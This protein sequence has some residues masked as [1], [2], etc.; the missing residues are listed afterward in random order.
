[1]FRPSTNIQELVF[2]LYPDMFTTIDDFN[3]V[4]QHISWFLPRHYFICGMSEAER[5]K[6]FAEL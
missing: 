4:M 2:N 5:Q 6:D 3:I 1:M